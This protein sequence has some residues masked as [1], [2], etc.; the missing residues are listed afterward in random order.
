MSS[1]NNSNGLQ[2]HSI[3]AH[4][5]FRVGPQTDAADP[6]SS[7]PTF[8]SVRIGTMPNQAFRSMGPLPKL[9]KAPMV[10]SSFSSKPLLATSEALVTLT[11]LEEQSPKFCWIV[12]VLPPMPEFYPLERTVLKLEDVSLSDLCTRVSDFM[13]EKSIKFAD[14][15]S[16]EACI[17]CLTP[18]RLKFVVQLWKGDEQ[19]G[20]EEEAQTI[21]IEVQRRRGCAIEMKGIRNCLYHA[22]ENGGNGSAAKRPS[23]TPRSLPTNFLS[24]ISKSQPFPS[25]ASAGRGEDPFGTSLKRCACLL[26]SDKLDLQVLGLEGLCKSTDPTKV[27]LEDAKR[28]AGVVLLGDSGDFDIRD[29][30]ERIL[31]QLP[32]DIDGSVLND[33]PADAVCQL[34]LELLSTALQTHLE[35][36]TSVQKLDLSDDFWGVALAAFVRNL[37]LAS[38]RPTEAALSAKSIRLLQTVEPSVL[39]MA[40]HGNDLE[41][42][43]LTAYQYGKSK[44]SSL[45]RESGRLMGRVSITC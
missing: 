14:E 6:P 44:H 10:S 41:S 4:S 21:I 24:K 45:E 20:T 16:S 36:E 11:N 25:S 18:G 15:P 27:S 9:G 43:L 32:V 40:S 31:E 19:F 37:S 30:I 13:R 7:N 23:H 38:S 12:T 2:K 17:G 8:Q 28:V 1:N 39:T 26:T 29:A 35:Q 33:S 34:A 22:I 5:A 3:G 42:L